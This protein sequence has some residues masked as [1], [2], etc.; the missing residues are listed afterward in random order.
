MMILSPLLLLGIWLWHERHA[1]SLR[2]ALPAVLLLNLVL[3]AAHVVWSFRA[4]ISTLYTEV[5]NYRHPPAFLRP[6]VYVARGQE[7]CS[8]GQ[9]AEARQDCDSA[10]RLGPATTEAYLLRAVVRSQLR[11][12]RGAWED[13]ETAVRLS[14]G[15]PEALFLRARFHQTRGEPDQAMQ[16]LRQ[17]LANAPPG[18]TLRDQALAL[19]KQWT[20]SSPASAPKEGAP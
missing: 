13:V 15:M 12:D 16:D 2:F 17:A 4:P 1:A 3:P 9:W 19:L 5:G 20:E 18:W 14:P 7:R 8:E 6:A 11:D 10:I